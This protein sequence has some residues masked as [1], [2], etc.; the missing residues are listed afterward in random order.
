MKA[1][2]KAVSA[3]HSQFI[4]EFLKAYN[5]SN[6]TIQRLKLGDRQRNI[7]TVPG[8]LALLGSLYF[9]D[10]PV[11]GDLLAAVREIRSLPVIKSGKIR[12]ILVTDFNDVVA[13][14]LKV[15]DQLT[16]PFDEFKTQYE[17][18]LPLTGL[19]EKPVAYAEHPADTKA[20]EKMGRLYDGIRSINRYETNE[21]L[22]CLNVFLTRLLFCFFA[23]D[24]GIFPGYNLMTDAITA[25]TQ[26]DGSDLPA[27]FEQLFAILG[28]EKPDCI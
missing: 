3:P 25:N 4:Y 15:D 19:Y 26:R 5:I 10:V 14:D 18:F 27:F 28:V 8:D 9:R 1:V 13:V 21:D 2:E 7:V 23:E 24:T 11:N 12:F 17:F 6:T 16:F 20:C 22:Q